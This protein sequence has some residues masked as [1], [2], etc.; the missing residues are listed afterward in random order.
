MKAAREKL[1]RPCDMC[2]NYEA[3]LQ[4]SQEAKKRADAQV[5]TLERQLEG[6]R[7]SHKNH[8]QYTAELEEKLKNYTQDAED[9]VREGSLRLS[10]SLQ[11]SFCCTLVCFDT[12]IVLFFDDIIVL[13]VHVLK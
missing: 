3:Q 2:N 4:E 13:N 12:G 7:Q 5:R 9:E 11:K 1:G 10:E 8:E 6:E